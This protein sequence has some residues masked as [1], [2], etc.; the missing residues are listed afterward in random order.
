MMDSNP[1]FIPVLTIEEG[2]LSQE[3]EVPE[4]LPILPLR[5]SVLYPGVVIP[6]TVGR[7]KSIQL[8]KEYYRKRKAIGVI[9]Q[10]NP[11][12]EDPTI[13]DLYKV[14]TAAQ[15]IKTLQM[16]DGNTTVIIHNMNSLVYPVP[17]KPA[18]HVL[19]FFKI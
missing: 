3:E 8:V 15:I 14:G 11:D 5:N 12:V 10:V 6:I 4:E 17:D 9:A 16:P 18:A 2:R 13:D 1:E 7:D 19:I